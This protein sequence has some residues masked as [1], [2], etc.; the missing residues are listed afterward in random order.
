LLKLDCPLRIF[1]G[2][3][4]PIC[5]VSDAREAAAAFQKAGKSN[6]VV[7]TYPGADHGLDWSRETALAGGPQGFQDA[8]A[9]AVSL[10]AAEER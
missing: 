10:L 4:D 8:F 9:A 2:E 1:H 3:L 7:K 5:C 6:L